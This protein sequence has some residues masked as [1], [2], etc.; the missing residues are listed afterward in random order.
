MPLL[1]TDKDTFDITLWYVDNDGELKISASE[2]APANTIDEIGRAKSETF[3][4]RWPNWADTKTMLAGSVMVDENGGVAVDPFKFMDGKVRTLLKDWTLTNP[5]GD[6]YPVNNMNI[7]KLH[8]AL[9]EYLNK[10]VEA[11]LA[12]KFQMPKP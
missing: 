9:F 4:F 6:K 2:P 10:T 11:R 3:T 7:D 1:L 5:K 8:P 12:G